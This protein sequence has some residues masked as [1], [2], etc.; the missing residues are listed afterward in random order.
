MSSVN[1]DEFAHLKIPLESILTATSNFSAENLTEK[2]DFGNAYM[3]Q[4]LWSDELIQIDA[5]RFNKD[6]WDDEKEQQFWMEISLLSTL[7]HKNLVSLVG[8]CD[9]NGEK[10]IIIKYE[11]YGSLENYLSNP[12]YLTWVRRLE[13]CICVANALSYVHYGNPHDL[14]IIHRNIDSNAIL[15]NDNFEPKLS[16]FKLSMKTKASQRHDSFH[17][18]KVWDKEGYTDPTYIKTKCVSHKSDIYSFGVVMFE[19]LCG[20]KSVISND[21]SKYLAP[22]AITHY[23]EKRLEYI[24]D[25][26]LW[27]QM[28]WESFNIFAETAYDCLNEEPSQRPN[29]DEIVPKLEK[30]LK[31]ACENRPVR[32]LLFSSIFLL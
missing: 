10:I 17:V 23:R 15:L 20:R 29:I 30:A 12:M 27:I 31:L 14:S 11:S 13:I 18:D 22:V 2:A 25:W 16:E 3:G 9:E 21:T 24:I 1:H 28:D 19:L 7:R 26:D 8:F 4:I 6:E 32:S 5:R